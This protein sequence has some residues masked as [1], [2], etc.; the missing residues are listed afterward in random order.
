MSSLHES[1]DIIADRYRILSVLGSGGM[2]TTYEAEDTHDGTRVAMK[3][4]SMRRVTDWKVVE[5]FDREAKVLANL[6]HPNIPNYLARFQLDTDGDRRFY[7]IQELAPGTSLATL[8][9]R[10]WKPTEKEVKRIVRKVLEIL[11]Y[12]HDLHPPVIH[13]DIK[14]QNI[15]RDDNGTVYLVDFGAV[16]DVYRNTLTRGGTFVGTLGYMAHEQ[17]RGEVC[18]ASDLYGL[19]ATALFLLSG[20]SPDSFPQKRLK[21][22]FRDRVRVSSEFGDWLEKIL[23]PSIEDRFVCAEEAIDALDR[24]EQVSATLDIEAIDLKSP[25]SLVSQRNSNS[26][27]YVIPASHNLIWI[28][29]LSSIAIV[30]AIA[31]GIYPITLLTAVLYVGVGSIV[32]IVSETERWLVID[33]DRFHFFWRC[34]GITYYQKSGKTSDIEL[35]EVETIL[36]SQSKKNSWKQISILYLWEGVFLRR[37]AYDF[38]REDLEI[39]AQEIRNFIGIEPL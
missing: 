14:P 39:M 36:S 25:F 18:G 32:A 24:T 12:L 10:G 21:L 13:R 6:N 22:Q 4:V 27:A 34:W 31:I 1:N 2:G 38:P 35:V 20:K 11:Q 5:L 37:F 28:V 3:V 29:L 9:E 8:I 16:Q 26:L 7:L 15:V 19:G 33:R 23:E 30:I 17:F